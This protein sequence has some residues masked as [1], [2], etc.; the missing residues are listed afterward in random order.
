MSTFE[1]LSD[2]EKWQMVRETTAKLETN[3]DAAQVKIAE[4]E[5]RI[6]N[7]EEK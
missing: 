5:N 1:K 3:L 2:T 7:L 6:K 4:L